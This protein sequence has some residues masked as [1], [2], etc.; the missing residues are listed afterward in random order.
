MNWNKIKAMLVE[1][2]IKQVDIANDLGL[3]RS[4][5]NK[6]L[7]GHA[8]SHRIKLHIIELLGDDCKDYWSD[9]T[10][11]SGVNINQA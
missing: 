6:V 8:K 1:R 11:Y 7:N 2:G 9:T 3:T 4:A 5:V 10:C